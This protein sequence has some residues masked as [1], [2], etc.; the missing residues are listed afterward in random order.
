MG[1]GH[2]AN[3]LTPKEIAAAMGVD[4]ES[5]RRI[6]KR[7]DGPKFK[8]YGNRFLIRLDWYKSWLESDFKKTK[9]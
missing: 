8:R 6:L 7:G 1:N 4:Y 5:F 2:A 9:D 3:F